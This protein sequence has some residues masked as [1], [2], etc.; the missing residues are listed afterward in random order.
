MFGGEFVGE[1]A[2]LHTAV[3]NVYGTNLMLEPVLG[4]P[5][6]SDFLLTGVLSDG[7]AISNGVQIF[8]SAQLNLIAVPEPS[9]LALLGIGSLGLI[10]VRRRRR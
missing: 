4:T 7:T 3:V 10:T 2:L 5:D 6:D 1:F 8:D 9:S